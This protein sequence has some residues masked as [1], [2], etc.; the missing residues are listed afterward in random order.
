MILQQFY[1]KENLDRWDLKL[2]R[3]PANCNWQLAGKQA[4]RPNNH[5]DQH[6]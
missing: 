5:N 3:L 2:R 4:A 1:M 6:T